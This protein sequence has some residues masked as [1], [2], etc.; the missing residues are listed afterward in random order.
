MEKE[1]LTKLKVSDLKKLA[2]EKDIDVSGL[3]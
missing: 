3:K 2:K 1:D